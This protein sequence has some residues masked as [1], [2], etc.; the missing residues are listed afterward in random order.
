MIKKMLNY[1]HKMDRIYK[2]KSPNNV[3]F[4][5]DIDKCIEQIKKMD[6][7]VDQY[8]VGIVQ[9]GGKVVVSKKRRY[10]GNLIKYEQ[11]LLFDNEF[12][13]KVDVYGGFRVFNK[14]A[15]PLYLEGFISHDR[16]MKRSMHLVSYA[17]KIKILKYKARKK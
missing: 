16:D 12:M 7:T 3:D 9:Y 11:V 13:F 2:L 1:K 14:K 17:R 4:K 5:Y 8:Y 6:L 15:H 10:R